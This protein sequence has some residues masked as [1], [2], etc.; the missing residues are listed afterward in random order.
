MNWFGSRRPSPVTVRSNL[1]FPNQSRSYD[2][3]RHGVRFWGNDNALE[4]A[5]F[6]SEEALRKLQSD[7]GSEEG[8]LLRAFDAHRPRILDA[9]IKVYGRGPRGVYDLQGNEF[10]A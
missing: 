3:T 5:F 8:D 1:G 10:S 2:A 6:V 7:I 4:A 9:A